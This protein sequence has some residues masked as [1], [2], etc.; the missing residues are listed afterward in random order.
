MPRFWRFL[1]LS[2]SSPSKRLSDVTKKSHSQA[3]IDRPAT[4]HKE[5]T[6]QALTHETR[7][8]AAAQAA[9]LSPLTR[10]LLVEPIVAAKAPETR[11]RRLE[12]TLSLLHAGK[13]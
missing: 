4:G 11:Q 10:A 9:T 13:R 5:T 12:K 6:M 1:Y 3:T 8:I 7:Q 2:I